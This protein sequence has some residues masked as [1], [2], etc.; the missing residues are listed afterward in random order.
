[1]ENPCGAIESVRAPR[2]NWCPGDVTPPF[3]FAPDAW[4]TP[5]EH[6]FGFNVFGVKPGGSWRTSA[7]VFAFGPGE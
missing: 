3:T 6:R 7:V 2:A 4:N 1:M 5:G